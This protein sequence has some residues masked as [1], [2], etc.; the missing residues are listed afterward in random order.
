MGKGSGHLNRSGY[1][2]AD[3]GVKQITDNFPAALDAAWPAIYYGGSEAARGEPG[4][5][6]HSP[7]QLHSEDRLFMAELHYDAPSGEHAGGNWYHAMTSYHWFVLLVASLAWLFDC[8]DQQLFNWARSKAMDDLVGSGG[9]TTAYGFFA[10][11]VFLAGWGTG[12][13]IFGAMGDRIGR[14]KTMVICIMIYSV[15]TGLS[16]LSQVFWDFS[17]YRFLTGMGVGG[18]FGVSVTLVAETVPSSARAGALGL[19][20]ALST[21]GNVSA[22]LI[23]FGLG[24]M[25]VE[26][27]WRWA[28]VVGAVPAAMAVLV[29]RKI[30]EPELWLRA[31]AEGKTQGGPIAALSDL[32]SDPVWRKR[33]L[34]GLVI[35]CAGIIGYWGIGVFSND[36]LRRVSQQEPEFQSLSPDIRSSELDKWVAVN[37]FMQ[38]VGAFFG[39][40][41]YARL[42]RTMGRKPTFAIA[43]LLA[44]IMTIVQFQGFTSHWQALWL[45]PILGFC[46]LGIFALYAIYFPELFPTRLRSTGTSFCYNVGRYVA[47]TGVAL[48]GFF[49]L[50]QQ[51]SKSIE[52]LRMIGSWTAAVYLIGIIALP[53]APETKGKPLPE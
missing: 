7:L 31:K 33:A 51:S 18:V 3:R 36:L 41:L 38:N 14:A 12:G 6:L 29:Q 17:V 9:N 4:I 13:L 22:A 30:K 34:V 40:M 48:Q 15:C 28:F 11:A 45:T 43:F 8:L 35:G 16:A 42:A 50:Q 5:A 52:T 39:M 25:K 37:L 49:A 1:T 20:Q 32:L 26:H 46:Q 19:L 2:S 10:T 27:A 21:V 24:Y 23:G 47:G 44:F 53:F